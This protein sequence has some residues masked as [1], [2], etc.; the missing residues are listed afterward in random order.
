MN[1][2]RVPT[3]MLAGCQAFFLGG[4]M[5][6]AVADT[7]QAHGAAGTEQATP[8]QLAQ[9]GSEAG[10]MPGG[11]GMGPGQGPGG[12]GMGPGMGPGGYGM[13]PGMGPGSYG[14]GPGGEPGSYGM[15]PGGEPGSYGMGPGGEPGGYGMGPGMQPGSYGM[16]P[17]GEPG[18]YGMGPGGEPGGYG[19]GPGGEPGGYGMGPG[20]GPGGYGMG[21]GMGPGGYGM[22][23]ARQ[24]GGQATGPGFGTPGYGMPPGGQQPGMMG[25]PGGGSLSAMFNAIGAMDL[26][27]EQRSKY[28]AI[29]KELNKRRQEIMTK[30]DAEA[31]KMRTLQEQQ[32][33]VGKSLT[34]LRGHMMEAMMDAAN[35]AE[36]L[37]TDEQ[38]QAMVAKG[39]H[40]MMTP[41]GMPY[42]EPK[43]G[44]ETE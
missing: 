36:E 28:D 8:H 31:K 5:S 44:E 30:I 41:Q 11:Y 20:M 6:L 1:V 15:G 29:S 19:M 24:Q 32:M 13:G 21:P 3:L 37:L 43:G 25:G 7:G 22:G 9:S 35:R 10:Q 42:S 23:P 33:Q 40:I 12:Y 17:G 18:S 4:M 26:S 39:R 34:D 38:R 16:G 2:N 27:D 14:M